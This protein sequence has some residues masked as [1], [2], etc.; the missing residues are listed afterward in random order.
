MVRLATID[1]PARVSYLSAMLSG[2]GVQVRV[3]DRTLGNPYEP[4]TRYELFVAEADAARA[5]ALLRQLEADA[6]GA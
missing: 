2:E 6:G 5:R 4:R 3:H 1:D